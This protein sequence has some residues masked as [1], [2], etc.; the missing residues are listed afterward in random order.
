MSQ[1]DT[2]SG[3]SRWPII[4]FAI[5]V[6]GIAALFEATAKRKGDTNSSWTWSTRAIR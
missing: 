6:C 5:V 1:S 3:I 4:V 2:S